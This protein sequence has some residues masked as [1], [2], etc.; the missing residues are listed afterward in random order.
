MAA[1][2]KALVWSCIEAYN[3]RD[4]DLVAGFFAVDALE[5]GQPVGR[6]GLRRTALSLFHA[7][8]DWQVVLESIVA[9]GDLVMTRAL[10]GGTHLGV[11]DA[12]TLFGGLLAGVP[13]TGKRIAVRQLQEWRVAGGVVLAQ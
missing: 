5:R 10:Q 13:P 1:S 7:F 8:P 12:P 3:A 6:E 9:E 4:A 11:L 2:N